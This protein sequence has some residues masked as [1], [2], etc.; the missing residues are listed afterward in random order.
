MDTSEQSQDEP[1]Y[2]ISVA[3]RMV[4]LH[5]QTLRKYEDEGLVLPRRSPGNIRLYS[6]DDVDRLHKIN[7]LS[8][9]LGVNLAGVHI[10]LNLTAQIETLHAEKEKLRAQLEA[11]DT[12]Q[13]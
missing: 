3:A 10:I 2:S 6:P 4:N 7:R 5:P 12:P 13:P 8:T 1:C 9:D 11:L